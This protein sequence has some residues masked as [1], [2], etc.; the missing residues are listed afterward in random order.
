MGSVQSEYLDNLREHFS[1]E[2][3]I[4][5]IK[6]MRYGGFMPTRIY[7]ITQSGRFKLGMFSEIANYIRS[8]NIPYKMVVTEPLKTQ[9]FCNYN[10]KSIKKLSYDLRDYQETAVIKGLKQGNGVIVSATASGKTYIIATLV[11]T[12]RQNSH[13]KHTTVILVPGIQLVEQTYKDFLE[14]G[15]NR[16]IITKW[17]G[18]NKLN[19]T[20]KII[21]AN[22]SILQ[23]KKS[24][25]SILSTCD[26]FIADE[27]HKFRQGN[28]VN[29]LLK[30]VKT[31]NRYGFSGT[32]PENKIDQWNIVGLFGPILMSKSSNELQKEDYIATSKVQ[33]IKIKYKDP[34]VYKTTATILDP[35]ARYNE[36]LDYIYDNE[37]RN[38]IITKLSERVDKNILIL[39][40]RIKHGEELT[41]VIKTC[42]KCKS[43]YFI[44]GQ[45]DVEDREKIRSIMETEDNIV[46]VAISS[47]FSTGI[48]IKNLHYILFA[49]AGKAK[50]KIIQSIGRGLRLHENKDMLTIFDVA[51]VLE[52]SNKHLYKRL[53]LYKKEKINY[54]I[55]E[56]VEK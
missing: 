52:Y 1:V 49:C 24:D 4:A 28:S 37:Y 45:V 16:N 7:A 44:R 47:I 15:I 40:D 17:S 23:S 42:T 48:N 32:M 34:L 20:A 38:G 10:I 27:V 12:I 11:E 18:N 6:K 46:C 9:Y 19:P 33:V 26:L 41:R 55:K 36:E 29:K 31:K 2:D 3:P 14:Y 8:L 50:I 53:L 43:V 54:A 5:G 13:K 25:I 56:I 51:D 21:I 39:V 35:T 22:I 30:L